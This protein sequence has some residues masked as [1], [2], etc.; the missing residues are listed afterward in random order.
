MISL[1]EAL[2]VSCLGSSCFQFSFLFWDYIYF[3]FHPLLLNVQ[4]RGGHISLTMT[5]TTTK[6]AGAPHCSMEHSEDHGKSGRNGIP[7]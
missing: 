4:I 2:A 3:H 7:A 5:R 6:M 1:T